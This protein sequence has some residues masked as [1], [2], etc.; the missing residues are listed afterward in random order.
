RRQEEQHRS[1]LSRGS[2][3]SPLD[4]DSPDKV[5]CPYELSRTAGGYGRRD[6]WLK[7]GSCPRIAQCSWAFRRRGP[8]DPAVRPALHPG[9][10]AVSPA[11]NFIATAI[12][13]LLFAVMACS[14]GGNV[15]WEASPVRLH[16]LTWSD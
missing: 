6:V 2:N 16:R 15:Q 4:M 10:H 11:R 7:S 14:P 1:P 5:T 8:A 9:A 13:L 12:V 3:C